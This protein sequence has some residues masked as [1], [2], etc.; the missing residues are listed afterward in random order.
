M[1]WLHTVWSEFIGLFVDDGSF[2][3]AILTWLGSCWL[4]LPRLGLD[5]V[6]PP[7]I[8]FAGLVLILVE[9]AARRARQG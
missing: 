1:G 4:V 5:P 2:A 3:V 6:W 9:R 8:L 7:L